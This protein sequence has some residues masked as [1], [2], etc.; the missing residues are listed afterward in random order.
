MDKACHLK[1]QGVSQTQEYWHDVVGF[2]YRMTNICAAIGLA[3]L[4]QADEILSK[5]RQIAAWYQ[6]GLSN[7]PLYMHAEIENTRHSYWMCSIAL[8]DAEKRQP[9]RD[10]LK[11]EGVETRPVFHL[12]H[13]LP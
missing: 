4:E 2:N 7:L 13:T 1:N 3:Q 11:A 6:E 8:N 9:L 10:Y 5:K 12:A